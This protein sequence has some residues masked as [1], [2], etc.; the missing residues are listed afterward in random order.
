MIMN[1]DDYI[2]EVERQLNDTKFYEKIDENP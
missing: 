1:R 2:R